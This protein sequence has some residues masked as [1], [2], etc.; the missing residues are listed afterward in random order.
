MLLSSLGSLGFAL[1]L[2]FI[3]ILYTP[4]SVRRDDSPR[5]DAFF[6]PS[7]IVYDA[8]IVASLLTLNSFPELISEYGDKSMLRLGYLA[9]PLFFAFAPQVSIPMRPFGRD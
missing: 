2:F 4:T 6:T 7:P 3:T 1:S 5:H 8:G 9:M